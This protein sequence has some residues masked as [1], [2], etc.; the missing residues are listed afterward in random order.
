M[1]LQNL[2]V[3]SS[4]SSEYVEEEDVGSPAIVMRGIVLVCLQYPGVVPFLG[5]LYHQT[6][7]Q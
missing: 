3:I 1:A 6:L 2:V 5:P 7:S 4:N